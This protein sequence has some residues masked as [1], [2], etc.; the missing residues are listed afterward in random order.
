[1]FTHLLHEI[2]SST[3]I[4]EP[5]FLLAIH[6]NRKMENCYVTYIGVGSFASQNLMTQRFDQK[7]SLLCVRVLGYN[8]FKVN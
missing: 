5:F 2:L 1:M 3:A 7:I 6:F 8:T 4:V